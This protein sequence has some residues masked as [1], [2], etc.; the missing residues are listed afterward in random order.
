MKELDL[1]YHII[2]HFRQ[3][4]EVLKGEANVGANDFFAASYAGLC[5]DWGLMREKSCCFTCCKKGVL[6]SSY[7]IMTNYMCIYLSEL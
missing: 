4:I 6:A 3:T 5:G 1:S 2:R 7:D